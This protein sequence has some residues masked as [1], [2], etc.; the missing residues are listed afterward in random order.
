MQDDNYNELKFNKIA[1]DLFKELREEKSSDSMS[2][3]AREYDF[4]RGNFS[5]IERGIV[6][7]RLI[8][9]WKFS[10]AVGI[11]FSDFAKRLEDKLG[12]DFKIIDE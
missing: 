3:F 12:K 8:T 1:G 2:Q 6:N 9:A 7:C 5:K 4:D 11:K 10:E